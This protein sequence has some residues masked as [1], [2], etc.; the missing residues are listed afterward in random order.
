MSGPATWNV[1]GVILKNNLVE[2]D[3][4]LKSGEQLNNL[5]RF[6][7]AAMQ[8]IDKSRFKIAIVKCFQFTAL[9]DCYGILNSIKNFP[10]K[11][12]NYTK[13]DHLQKIAFGV[14]NLN[15]TLSWFED[16]KVV[17]LG[18]FGSVLGHLGSFGAAAGLIRNVWNE[19]KKISSLSANLADEYKNL[20]ETKKNKMLA[21]RAVSCLNIGS[22][23]LEVTL[24]ATPYFIKM[25]KNFRAV[26]TMVSKAAA[27][28]AFLIE[29]KI[30]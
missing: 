5:C 20:K 26:I 16:K 7:A 2:F 29:Q 10:Y 17:D 19:R 8:I 25:N 4:I 21:Q 30:N 15:D 27:L 1:V 23:C 6:T 13:Y 22:N 12:F 24:I 18:R 14:A 11:S 3:S 9:A 28:G